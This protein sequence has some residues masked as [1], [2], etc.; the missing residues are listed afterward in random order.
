MPICLKLIFRRFLTKLTKTCT[1]KFNSRLLKQVDGGTM[2]GPLS[3]NFSIY[4]VKI[5]YVLIP[6]KH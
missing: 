5:E 2:G 1:Y 4:M 3:V 6:S